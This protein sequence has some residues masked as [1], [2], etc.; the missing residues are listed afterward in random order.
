VADRHDELTRRAFT[1]QATTFE[2]VRLNQVLTRESEWV[3]ERLPRG[4]RDVV[5]D[6]AAGTGLGSRTL[7]ADVAAVVAVDATEAMLEV[8]QREAERAGIGNIVFMR[9]AA[10]S[11]PFLDGSFPIVVCRYAV[12]HFADPDRPM[13]EMSRCLRPWGRLAVADMVADE[14]PGPAAA[15]NEIE[16]LRDPSH[17]RALSASEL[18]SLIVRHGLEA[19]FADS[20]AVRRPLE[21]W[22]EQ[23][24]TPREAREEV[25]RRLAA[26][27]DGTAG[28]ET[29]MQP[30]Y[31][32]DGSIS[33]V[34]TLTS[35]FALRP[36]ATFAHK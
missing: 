20:R 14:R 6:V 11:L 15:M 29:G 10:E 5:L 31:E 36:G 24:A 12:H 34:H 8:G 26:E 33:F 30:R 13:A 19:H 25:R 18:Q 9:A 16:R 2:D 32:Q 21:P 17:V 4:K 23:S 28:S 3:F 27:I 35:V 7:A 22:L 1:Q